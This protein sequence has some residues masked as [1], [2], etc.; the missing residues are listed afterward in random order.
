[1]RKSPE[2]TFE[3]FSYSYTHSK[4]VGNGDFIWTSFEISPFLP[5]CDRFHINAV[6]SQK[7]IENIRIANIK[8]LII[9]L[10]RRFGTTDQWPDHALVIA[11]D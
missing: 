2:L 1:M 11:F 8:N 7:K 6:I 10:S 9:C 4:R 3:A 5:N